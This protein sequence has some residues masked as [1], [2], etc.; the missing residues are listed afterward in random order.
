MS[1]TQ[2]VLHRGLDGDQLVMD[3]VLLK[4]ILL[5]PTL[6]PDH[7]EEVT[8]TETHI[9]LVFL[10]GSYVYK[11]KKAVDFG[12]LDFTSL[13]KRKYYCEREVTLNR[14][15]SPEIYL[16]VVGITLDGERVSLNGG[17]EVI[18]YAVRMKQVPEDRFLD[19]LLKRNQ[20]TLEMMD[21]LSEK[22][23]YFYRTAE[24]NDHIKRFA[25]PERI[26]QDTDE[27]FEQT[28]KYVGV[29]IPGAIYSEIQDRTDRFFETREG[30]FH[31]R[32]DS[33]FIRDCH[34]DLRLEHIV[35]GEEIAILDCI[36]FNERFRYTDV[37]ADI[38]FL[39]MDLDYHS[40][41]DLSRR[42]VQTYML[43]SGDRELPEILD[44]YQCY[45]AYVRGK[46]ESFRL[47]D[48]GIPEEE[49][50]EALRRA[51]DYFSLSY[52]YARRF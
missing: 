13:E 32:M 12:F 44:F 48:P 37:A 36:E 17:G 40:R 6:Y 45:R 18:E 16:G 26:R 4:K 25:R 21:A 11:V 39:T 27:N 10:T 1:S 24:T 52:R 9:S 46:V 41:E 28:R 19:R 20:I 50:K 15:L 31:R 43:K 5:D 14:R 49:K 2:S 8:W 3:I 7:P 23:V 47:E 38:G 35:W 33:G 51:R 22:L 30:L 42:F 34:G 29:T